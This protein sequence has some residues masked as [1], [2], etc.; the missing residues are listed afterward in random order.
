[1]KIPDIKLGKE[2]QC[3]LTNQL[4]HSFSVNIR[5]CQPSKVMF[6]S[7][8]CIMVEPFSKSTSNLKLGNYY[9]KVGPIR[10]ENNFHKIKK[11][12]KLNYAN[13]PVI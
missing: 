10:I 2:R 8:N 4:V 7:A 1:M 11:T 12:P 13:M 5:I 3:Q 6:T 9:R